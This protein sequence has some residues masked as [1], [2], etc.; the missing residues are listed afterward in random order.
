MAKLWYF[1]I[2][3]LAR[4]A[5]FLLGGLRSSGKVP[6]QGALIVAPVH[7]S[8]LDPPA[9]ACACN[10]M[11]RFMAKEELFRGPFGWLIQ[12]VG[13]FPVRRGEGDTESIRH[14]IGFLEQGQAVLMFPEGTRGDGVRLGPMS[15]GVALIAKRTGAPVLPVA[16]VGS[17]IA[18][19]R[20]RS[21][22]RRAR[23]KVVYGEP[24]TFAEVAGEGK[25]DRDRFL[26]ALAERLQ[27]LCAEHGL[28]LLLPEEAG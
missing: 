19:P 6:M 14:T 4:F 22:P 1:F 3:N 11:L 20:G 8:H 28:M 12:S 5:F 16:I 25:G 10:R 15:K 7:V 21:K 17:H 13:A 9:V 23:I 24:F 26:A 27:T 2:L 18:L